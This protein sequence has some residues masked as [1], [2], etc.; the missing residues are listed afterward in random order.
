MDFAEVLRRRKAVRTYRRSPDASA[1][2][3]RA[4]G[5]HRRGWKPID[6]VVRWQRR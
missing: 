6:E 3:T 5:S 4:S 1:P 2:E